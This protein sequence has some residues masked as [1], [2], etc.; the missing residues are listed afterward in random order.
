VAD[1]PVERYAAAMWQRFLPDEAEPP[2]WIERQ[3]GLLTE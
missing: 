2:I 1:N 3:L